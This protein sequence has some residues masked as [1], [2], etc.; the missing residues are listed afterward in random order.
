MANDVD[1]IIGADSSKLQREVRDATAELD[2]LRTASER[3]GRS[4]VEMDRA[5]AGAAKRLDAARKAAHSAGLELDKIPDIGERIDDGMARTAKAAALTGDAFGSL[6]G[7]IGDV[8]DAFA[9][10]PPAMAATVVGAGAVVSI[11]GSIVSSS[12]D[13]IRNLD[14]YMLVMDGT[15][16]AVWDAAESIKAFD[17]AL[18][19]QQVT[20][21]EQS[22]PIL[23][24][25][26]NIY[27]SV[28]DNIGRAIDFI[29]SRTSAGL[30]AIG[31]FFTELMSFSR[32]IVIETGKML[33]L[34]ADTTGFIYDSIKSVADTTMGAAFQPI[35][36]AMDA[37]RALMGQAERGQ[38]IA[39]K[40]LDD[41]NSKLS[42]QQQWTQ[43]W[44]DFLNDADKADKK[45]DDSK[46]ERL[47]KI[48]DAAN[49]VTDALEKFDADTFTF[50]TDAA[51]ITSSRLSI[52][53]VADMSLDP[54]NVKLNAMK[55]NA[56]AAAKESSDVW[57]E[58]ASGIV[59]AAASF[60]TSL[61]GMVS[62]LASRN[63]AHTRAERLKQFRTMKAAALVEASINTALGV[64]QSLG[65][66]P[67]PAN[68]VL[69]A[70]TLAAGGV[71]I[72]LIASQQPNFHRGGIMRSDRA[73]LAGDERA[74]SATTRANEAVVLTQQ[75]MGAFAGQLSR[76]NAGEGMGGGMAPVYV[77]VDGRASP[78]RQ[79]A[80]P[81]PLYGR[82]RLA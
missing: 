68:I 6:A 17:I 75:A 42:Q 25:L 39:Q 10:M 48:K 29:I 51:D 21:A 7:P 59:N 64:T 13:V 36:M 14:D 3:M 32:F 9:M 20:I 76:V 35:V 34:S 40:K 18:Q 81:D 22:A 19:Q 46:V 78:T 8:G 31:S 16:Q 56:A 47:V 30:G 53:V 23:G 82:R 5:L 12:L 1:I 77:M 27:I 44:E 80:R 52:D 72:G 26:A 69:G 74:F 58:S 65:S 37:V 71:Q 41:F 2:R 54:L 62:E 45:R 33:G 15:E 50:L 66:A 28:S 43:S 55:A 24:G 38:D 4:S 61:T 11:F 60:A 63:T 79:F 67:F 49:D 57:K 73:G 70:L